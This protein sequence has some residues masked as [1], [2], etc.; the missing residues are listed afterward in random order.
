MAGAIRFWE[1]K[2]Y[3]DAT[4][5]GFANGSYSVERG[6]Q[7]FNAL[8]EYDLVARRDATRTITGT[9]E[10]GYIDA[11]WFETM[12]TGIGSNPF[13]FDIRASFTAHSVK[14]SGCSIDTFDFEFPSDG[15][16]TE[17]I[18]FRVKTIAKGW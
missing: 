3:K 5:I 1:A 12:A 11:T 15:W 7:Y 2:L 9:L 18:S 8:G 16:I 6:T 4:E 13:T 10:H 14:L 17:T